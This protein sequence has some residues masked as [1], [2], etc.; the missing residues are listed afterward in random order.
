MITV[1]DMRDDYLGSPIFK[2]LAPSTRRIYISGLDRFRE[3]FGKHTD[4]HE[5]T[6]RTVMEFY[7]M[8]LKEHSE[9]MVMRYLCGPSAAFNFLISLRELSI[10]PISV[11]STNPEYDARDVVWTPLERDKFIKQAYVMGLNYM[12]EYVDFLYISAQR[13]DEIRLFRYEHIEVGSGGEG[14]YFPVLQSKTKVKAPVWVSDKLFREFEWNRKGQDR[15][16]E[17]LLFYKRQGWPLSYQTVNGD[18]NKIKE[19]AG[20]RDELQLRDIR[21]SRATDLMATGNYSAFEVMA[22][23]G[24]QNEKVFKEVYV[25]LPQ[26]TTQWMLEEN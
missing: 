13:V 25:T 6:P 26:Q 1:Q 8:M 5:I 20:L 16:T 9:N 10:N 11:L 12:A 15:P 21:R 2:K 24:H 22:L 3:Y 14:E 23:T 17:G 18:F 19:A 7:S 4:I